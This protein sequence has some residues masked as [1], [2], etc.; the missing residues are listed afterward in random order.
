MALCLPSKP[1]LISE[2]E[3][4]RKTDG[5][6]GAVYYTRGR[7]ERLAMLIVLLMI[8]VLLVV[9]IY[10]LN[11]LTE[12]DRNPHANSQCVGVLLVFTLAFSAC[13]SLFTRAGRH[14]ILAASAAYCAVLVV[15]IGNVG[16]R[17]AGV[18]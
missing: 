5:E 14:E 2:Q 12:N 7:I 6:D 11:H 10:I 18:N 1:L 3:T 16:G 13:I 17:I 4:K 8:L 15:F 9:P